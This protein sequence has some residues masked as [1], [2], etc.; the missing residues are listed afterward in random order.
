MKTLLE[1]TVGIM[2]AH[3]R[4]P[5]E[6]VFIG[7]QTGHSCNWDEF[8]KLANHKG[9]LDVARDLIIAFDGGD[10]MKWDFSDPRWHPGWDYVRAFKIP[11]KT[12]KI[13]TVYNVFGTINDTLAGLQEDFDVKG[14]VNV[15][16]FY[17]PFELPDW[18]LPYLMNGDAS[19]LLDSEVEMVHE[20]VK[21][22]DGVLRSWGMEF[23]H[24]VPNDAENG[25]CDSRFI[26]YP[27]FGLATNCHSYWICPMGR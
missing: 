4:T 9:H 11:E 6:I 16:G 12:F 2:T 8:Q 5:D 25:D 21:T 20:W 22:Q 15:E 1:T 3:N 10:Y 13:R 14:Q 7:S 23:G 18:S 27:A 26:S 17:G 19:G 24:F